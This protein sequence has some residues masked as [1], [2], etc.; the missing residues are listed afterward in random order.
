MCRPAA[1]KARK[2]FSDGNR[3]AIPEVSVS[4]CPG[5]GDTGFPTRTCAITK[6]TLSHKYEDKQSFVN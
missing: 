4:A 6:M 2:P 5:K 1:S 3:A